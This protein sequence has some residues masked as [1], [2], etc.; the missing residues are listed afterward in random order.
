MGDRLPAPI[1]AAEMTAPEQGDD[2]VGDLVT[3]ILRVEVVYAH[4]TRG[5]IEASRAQRD[6]DLKAGKQVAFL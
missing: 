3:G 4:M 2:D 1:D 6:S 5:R